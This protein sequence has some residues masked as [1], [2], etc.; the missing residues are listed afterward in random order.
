MLLFATRKVI[1][2]YLAFNHFELVFGQTVYRPFGVVKAMW[3]KLTEQYSLSGYVSKFKY[4]LYKACDMAHKSLK[5]SQDKLKTC[6]GQKITQK[7][8]REGDKCVS[9][10]TCTW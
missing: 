10:A 6:S 4:R 2:E 8:F 7:E 9:V 1:Q 3:L 5:E